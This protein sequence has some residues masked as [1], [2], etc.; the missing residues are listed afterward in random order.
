MLLAVVGLQAFTHNVHSFNY[1]RYS[2]GVVIVE[3]TPSG[4]S[5]SFHWSVCLGIQPYIDFYYHHKPQESNFILFVFLRTMCH[6]T[7]FSLLRR[8]S[9]PNIWLYV[10]LPSNLS[11]IF[12]IL[13]QFSGRIPICLQCSTLLSIFSC[14]V[15]L[16]EIF[17]DF[18]YFLK[19]I[20]VYQYFVFYWFIFIF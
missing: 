20:T 18:Y 2:W 13:I 9:I 11:K 5:N 3:S 14:I 7:D 12:Q 10:L 8:Q 15:I 1:I 4:L 19:I 6:L 16:I 17:N